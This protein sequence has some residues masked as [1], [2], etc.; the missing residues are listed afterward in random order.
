MTEELILSPTAKHHPGW[1][2]HDTDYVVICDGVHIGRI[3][4]S[5]EMHDGR[6]WVWSIT[7]MFKDPN[8]PGKWCGRSDTN[9]SSGTLDG[10]MAE[11]KSMWL[12]CDPDLEATRLQAERLRSSM[13]YFER[14][15][16]HPNPT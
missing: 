1:G 7:C 11:F 14:N 5:V 2:S 12:V 6:P 3:L 9:G 15:R 4:K 16:G 8:N 13:E 10:A